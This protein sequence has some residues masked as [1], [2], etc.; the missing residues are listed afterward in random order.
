MAMPYGALMRSLVALYSARAD[1]RRASTTQFL[2]GIAYGGFWA[3]L[4][5]MFAAV[6]QLGPQA[7]GL[8]GIPGAAGILL[9]RPA[10]R[11]MDRRGAR[12]VVLAGAALVLCAYIVFGGAALSIA[13]VVVGAALL[14]SGLRAAMVAN[15]A[16]VTGADAETRS[17]ANSLLAS[18]VWGG[19]A[20]GAFAA[21]T[22][23]AAVGWWGVC[24]VGAA[25]AAGALGLQLAAGRR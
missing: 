25:A 13:A 22:A 23:F 2:L 1:V 18:H 24:V 14:D 10:G 4:A 16:M 7:A 17:R 5:P 12:P 6:H 20:A 15:P 3:T 11:M 19:N 21:S 8:V 9:A